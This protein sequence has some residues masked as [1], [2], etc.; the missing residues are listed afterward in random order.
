MAFHASGGVPV[1]PDSIRQV[2]ALPALKRLCERLGLASLINECCPLAE[3][4]QVGRG[5][6]VVA[7]VLNKLTTPCPLY[8]LEEWAE[9]CT[10]GPL[11]GVRPSDLTDD[12]VA[13]TLDHLAEKVE[14]VKTAVCLAAI[15]RFSIDVARFHWDLTSLD[16]EGAYECQDPRFAFVTY[17]YHHRHPGEKK[18]VRVAQMVT[19]DGGVSVLHKTYSGNQADVNCAVDYLD[20]LCQV[21]DKFGKT[22]RLVGD[23]KLLSR[24]AMIK[25]EDAGL[26]WIFPE[27]HT[28]PLAKIYRELAPLDD[29]SWTRL[30]YVSRRQQGLPDLERT[31][32]RAQEK[33]LELKVDAPLPEGGQDK[34]PVRSGRP[35]RPP[36][37]KKVYR[38]RRFIIWSSEE[39]DAQR[40]NREAQMQRIESSL[41]EKRA[42]L[43]GQYWQRRSQSQA[44]ESV[45]KVL[46]ARSTGRF[47]SVQVTR[48]PEGLGWQL[49]WK[50][51]EDIIADAESLDGF[52][53]LLSNVP[54]ESADIQE[55]FRDYKAQSSVERRFADWKGPLQVRPLFLKKNKRIEGLVLVL[56]LALLVF[57]LLEREVRAGLKDEEESMVGLL[58]VKRA[59][60][61]TGKN[62]LDRLSSITIVGGWAGDQYVWQSTSPTPVQARLL[63]MLDVDLPR[64]LTRMRSPREP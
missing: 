2:G 33:V 29:E 22:P 10:A 48:S 60:R 49:T 58:P 21:R 20:L 5:E 27:P 59:V 45:R 51:Q 34:N 64:M 15:E 4:A 35:G 31:D 38:F 37:P 47:I 26:H 54:Q 39:R 32:Y 23:S 18:Q 17:G 1:V 13:R 19:G 55:V 41:E 44:E 57:S 30:D 6:A 25:L 11:L 46:D 56:S 36:K 8:R 24:E 43:L 61:A 40:V 42:K 16:F 9:E 53:S 50:R 28:E 7:L 52:Y 63:Q 3:Q 12:R 14:E 62:V